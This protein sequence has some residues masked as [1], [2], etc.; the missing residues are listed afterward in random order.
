MNMADDAIAASAFDFNAD[1]AVVDGVMR[2]KMIGT[3]D[4]SVRPVLDDFLC[5]VHVRAVDQRVTEAVL[6][7][8][9]LAFMNSSCLME[10]ATWISKILELPGEERYRIVVLSTPETHWQRRS[11]EALSRLSNNLVTVQS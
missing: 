5:R 3:A 11:F 4:M 2:V 8:R 6:D 7:V 9:Q 1:A 10:L